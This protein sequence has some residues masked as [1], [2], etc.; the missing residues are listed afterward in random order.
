MGGGQR[1]SQIYTYLSVLSS[2]RPPAIS[3]AYELEQ[4]PLHLVRSQSFLT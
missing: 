3:N 1:P 4:I 2:L